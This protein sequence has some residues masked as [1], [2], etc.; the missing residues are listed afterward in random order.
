MQEKVQGSLSS[1]AEGTVKLRND[2]NMH[3]FPVKLR[4]DFVFLTCLIECLKLPEKIELT[5]VTHY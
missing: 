2:R 1:K 4:C 5:C 3:K